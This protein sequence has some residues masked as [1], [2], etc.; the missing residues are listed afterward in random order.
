MRRLI[1]FTALFCLAA[2]SFGGFKAK[3]IKA[4]RPD[5]F[6]ARV[7][8]SGI[9]IAADLLLTDKEQ[10]QFFPRALNPGNIIALR[11]A[12]F[13]D[14]KSEVTIPLEGIRLIGPDG[15]ELPGISPEAVAQT[16]LQ[17]LPADT[18]AKEPPVKVAAGPTVVRPTIDGRT[19]RSSPTYDPRLDPNSPGYD[20]NDPR[21]R[22]YG[23]V[24]P[25]VGVILNPGGG[26]SGGNYDEIS[27]RL[28][29]KDFMDKAYAAD[30][31]M[32]S[33]SRDRFLYFS[34]E[35]HPSGVKGFELRLPQGK[36]IFEGVSLKF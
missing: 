18:K 20:P 33:M 32:P 7:S 29:E 22:G 1:L 23:R 34:F 14:T 8:V 28:M 4:K 3:A 16:V 10:T 35:E 13:N 2:S 5:K 25:G 31:I 19:D 30:P 24:V 26:S 6:Q 11:L 12:I 36:G 15:K 17:G 21:N 27:R 9:T